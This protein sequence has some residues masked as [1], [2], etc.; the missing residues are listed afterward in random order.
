MHNYRYCGLQ[1]KNEDIEEELLE[2]SD[3]TKRKRN[4]DSI[5]GDVHYSFGQCDYKVKEKGILKIHIES[6]HGDMKYT[7]DQC[8]YISNCKNYDDVPLWYPCVLC[9]YKAKE[10]ESL[11]I[12]VTS[13]HQDVVTGQNKK[14]SGTVVV[15]VITRQ[16]GKEISKRI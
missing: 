12:H 11:K 8:Y 10:E 15:S 3:S 9:T 16:H 1:F 2:K 4:L 6:I 13:V 7:C 14:F 5:L